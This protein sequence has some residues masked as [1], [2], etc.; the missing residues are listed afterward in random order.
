MA[1]I[2]PPGPMHWHPH[3][4]NAVQDQPQC[5]GGP[6]QHGGVANVK[7]KAGICESEDCRNLTHYHINTKRKILCLVRNVSTVSS[8]MNYIDKEFK[9]LLLD[10]EKKPDEVFAVLLQMI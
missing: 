2:E 9:I 10:Q 3:L 5:P 8:S 6:L 7:L 1:L 4:V